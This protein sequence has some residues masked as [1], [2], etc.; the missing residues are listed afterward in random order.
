[1]PVDLETLGYAIQRTLDPYLENL[2]SVLTRGV[3]Q[4]PSSPAPDSRY[5]VPVGATGPWSLR[6]QQI[7]TFDAESL[8]WR[9]R[10]PQEGTSIWVDDEGLRLIWSGS[11]WRV[12]SKSSLYVADEVISAL[13]VVRLTPTG[14]IRIARL[15]EDESRAPLG[16]TTQ[17]GTAGAELA[18]ETLGVVEDSSWNWQVGRGV[19]LGPEGAVIQ[20]ILPELQYLVPVGRAVSP[21][22]IYVRMGTPVRLAR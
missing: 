7:A 19:W 17:A 18:V 12:E 15:S 1:M 21:I 3:T 14:T 22:A 13:H 4:R 2:N 16:V 11:Q 5:L 8:S 20:Q 6:V 10:Q 9:Y